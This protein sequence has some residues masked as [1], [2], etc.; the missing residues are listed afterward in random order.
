VPLS[1][2]APTAADHSEKEYLVLLT[3]TISERR[4]SIAIV[5]ISLMAFEATCWR[6]RRMPRAL[7]SSLSPRPYPVYFIEPG[8]AGSTRRDRRRQAVTG[9]AIQLLARRLERFA[10][11]MPFS[12]RAGL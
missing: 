9:C 7:S 12:R 2:N 3:T 10:S 4:R 6:F 5:I 8:S 1:Y 11:D